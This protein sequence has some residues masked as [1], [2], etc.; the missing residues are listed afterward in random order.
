VPRGV[1][2]SDSLGNDVLLDRREAAHWV[3]EEKR[4]DVSAEVKALDRQFENHSE[5]HR[6]HLV[7]RHANG[8]VA[9]QAREA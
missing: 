5:P 3:M 1:H 8:A 4:A 6:L 7:G 2:R 9:R